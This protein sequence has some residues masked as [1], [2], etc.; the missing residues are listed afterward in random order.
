MR[1]DR[2]MPRIDLTDAEL[3]TVVDALDVA[4][5]R[6]P[7]HLADD[8]AAWALYNRLLT[9]QREHSDD[10]GTDDV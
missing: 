6:A 3:E 2:R 7:E 9:L 8:E 1:K 4:V 10:E 5:G